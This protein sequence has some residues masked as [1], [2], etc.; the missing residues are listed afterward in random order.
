MSTQNL[1][2]ARVFQLVQQELPVIEKCVK[3]LM[4]SGSFV[5]VGMDNNHI[6]FNILSNRPTREEMGKVRN[7]SFFEPLKIT[8]PAE[9]KPYLGQFR[10]KI[11]V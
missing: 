6:Y 5:F 11:N 2:E 8:Y 4:P 3:G 9:H 1:V 10:C 7:R